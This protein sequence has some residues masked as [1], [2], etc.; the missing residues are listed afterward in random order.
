[1]LKTTNL[2]NERDLEP[3]FQAVLRGLVER[4]PFLK[5]K[6][7]AVDVLVSKT[8]DRG[9]ADFLLKAQIGSQTWTLIAEG[10]RLGQPREVNSGILQ[11]KHYLS[12]L[13]SGTLAY[14]LLLAPFISEESARLCKE[15]GVGYLDLA[16]NASL[17]FDHIFIET[18]SSENPFH[19]KRAVKS[20][21]SPKATR[22]IRLLLQGPLHSWR[23][24]EL[25]KAAEVS[26]G[27]V[28]GVRQLLLAHE[29][30][31]EDKSGLR[32][33]KPD[34]VLDA[35]AALD[36]WDNRTTE[37]E[38]S[39]LINDPSEIAEK[40]N[41]QLGKQRHAFTQWFAASRR[42]PHA[43]VP[44]VTAYVDRFPDD[45]ALKKH[46]LARPV[47]S[48]GKL[49]LVI[50]KDEGVFRPSQTIKGLP[51]VSDVQ[52]YLDVIH[53]GL[54]GDEA[55]AELRRWPDFAGGWS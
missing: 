9:R 6:S 25:A 16:G 27:H 11:L 55:A 46:L 45:E 52:I 17:S 50:P 34:A 51:L 33:I 4:V 44:L 2:P 28:S 15:A 21:F 40:L 1:M 3:Q 10:K 43:S 36:R 53:A 5:F 47:S 14:G 22:V 48:G 19:E 26:L 38:Y 12:L 18:R 42:H 7:L 32:L 8:R 29:W 24:A 30:A 54:R 37:R 31:A 13:P 41:K 23:V 49:R 35:W 39:L 20:V